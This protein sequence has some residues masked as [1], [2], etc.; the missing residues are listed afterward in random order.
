MQD[1]VQKEIC[2]EQITFDSFVEG[3]EVTSIDLR[4]RFGFKQPG[5]SVASY[6]VCFLSDNC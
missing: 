2:G 6:V 3:A 1:M 4:V 5:M